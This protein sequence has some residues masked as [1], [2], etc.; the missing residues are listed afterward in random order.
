MPYDHKSMIARLSNPYWSPLHPTKYLQNC[1]GEFGPGAEFKSRPS[2]RAAWNIFWAMTY[3]LT[4]PAQVEKMNLELMQRV[5]EAATN[6]A[7]ITLTLEGTQF[8]LGQLSLL[9]TH[10]QFIDLLH[11]EVMQ[12]QGAKAKQLMGELKPAAL[13]SVLGR[14]LQRS[15]DESSA[16]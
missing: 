8:S 16:H 11:R 5:I 9:M 2:F 6:L 7:R 4:A 15:T 14:R 13:L 12:L 10:Q 3:K 1:E